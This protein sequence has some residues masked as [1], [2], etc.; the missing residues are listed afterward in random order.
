MGS[1]GAEART[2]ILDGDKPCVLVDRAR[3]GARYAM[4]SRC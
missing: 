3:C 4:P 1:F 2:D